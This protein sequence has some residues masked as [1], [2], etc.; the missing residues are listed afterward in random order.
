MKIIEALKEQKRIQAK[1]NRNATQIT[2]YS[3]KLSNEKPFFDSDE[4]QTAETYQLIQSNIDLTNRYL[5]LKRCI[6]HTNLNSKHEIGGVSYSIT[7]L[8]NMKRNGIAFIL[9]TYNALTDSQVSRRLSSARST[10]S[11]AKQ[12]Q[13]ERLYDE[14]GKNE[15]L[16]KWQELLDN[17]D[18][19]LEVIN[20][21]TDLME[22]PEIPIVTL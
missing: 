16:L 4:A 21:T 6:D 15:A 20:A 1:I 22:L 9:S 13:I 3:C 17:I 12:V 10:D 18:S 11:N 5:W 2:Q 19:K 14:R 8:L 7:D